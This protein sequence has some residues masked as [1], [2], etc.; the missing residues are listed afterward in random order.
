M[1]EWTIPLKNVLDEVVNTFE[2]VGAIPSTS[3]T[4]HA[5]P[6]ARIPLSRLA[7]PHDWSDLRVLLSRAHSLAYECDEVSEVAIEA[8]TNGASRRLVEG[9]GGHGSTRLPERDATSR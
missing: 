9:G 6:A 1:V 7:R 3:S 5:L 8:L 2:E 4:P